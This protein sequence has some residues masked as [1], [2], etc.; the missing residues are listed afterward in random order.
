[1]EAMPNRIREL[2]KARGW[3]QTELGERV[4]TSGANVSDIERGNIDLAHHWLLRF[5]AVL[6]VKPADLLLPEHNSDSLNYDERELVE[7]YRRADEAQRG[8]LLGMAR[9]LVPDAPERRRA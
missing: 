5:A 8:Q 2:R 4:G 7:R 9:L 3:S 6:E 1:M